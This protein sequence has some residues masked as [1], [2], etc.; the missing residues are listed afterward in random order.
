MWH[1]R[2]TPY[3]FI[4]P[5][6][7]GFFVFRGAPLVGA[8]YASFT[9]WNIRTPPQWVGLANYEAMLSSSTFWQVLRNT[10]LFAL[11]FVPGTVLLA[12]AAAVVLNQQL[13]GMA[14]FRGLYF[15]PY[16][17]AMVAVA[18]SWNFI[19]AT[20]FGILNFVLTE[21]FGVA[22]PPAWL[23]SS[24]WAL[25][26]IAIV[27]VWKNM[28]L[29]MLIYLAA[30]QN[31]PPSLYEAA[32]IDGASKWK[33]FTRITVPLLTP[34]TFFVLVITLIEA[35][36]TFEVTFVMTE[37][38]PQNASNTLAYF[39]YENAFVFN[40]MGYASALAMA[41]MVVVAAVTLLLFRLQKSRVHYEV[42]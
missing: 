12:M 16:I 19:F 38:G 5:A 29:M 1:G 33:Q 41:L 30:L 11:I 37:G 13:R 9:T 22:D 15:L 7:V 34:A 40:R 14:F 21:F 23:A 42:T 4:M 28:G 24:T 10:V 20:R 8:V 6:V 32:A 35:F 27:S 25:P 17:T 39:I 3:W 31:L 2:M 26:A 18:M 36:K